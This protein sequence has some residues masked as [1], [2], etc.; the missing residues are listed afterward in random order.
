MST[1]YLVMTVLVALDGG[2]LRPRED[3]DADLRQV[4]V[5][6]ETVGVPVEVLSAACRL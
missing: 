1:V 2:V 3:S 4:K 5:I 6:H